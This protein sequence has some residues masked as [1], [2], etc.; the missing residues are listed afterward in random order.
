MLHTQYVLVQETARGRRWVLTRCLSEG[1][2]TCSG[3]S[4]AAL[5]AARRRSRLLRGRRGDPGHG[6]ALG[7]AAGG[8]EA[9]SAEARPRPRRRA[10]A[11]PA[12]NASRRGGG[13]DAPPP[14]ETLA[15]EPVQLVVAG[16]AGHLQVVGA[17]GRDHHVHEGVVPAPA[18]RAG[19]APVGREDRRAVAAYGAS[20]IEL[21]IGVARCAGPVPGDASP[22]T[23]S[24]FACRS[25]VRAAPRAET[26]STETP[27]ARAARS[28]RGAVAARRHASRH[29]TTVTAATESTPFCARFSVSPRFA[30]RCGA[31]IRGG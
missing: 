28:L 16:V 21:S 11:L 4:P 12:G 19:V 8:P 23:G 22:G 15:D 6:D 31:L 5:D 3:S 13:A 1:T 9:G 27:A 10:P 18:D 24:A 25:R 26:A 30:L 2:Y 20:L 7:V 17:A 14:G 29:V